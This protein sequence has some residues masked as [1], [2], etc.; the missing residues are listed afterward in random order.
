MNQRVGEETMTTVTYQS[1]SMEMTADTTDAEIRQFVEY[2]SQYEFDREDI[3]EEEVQATIDATV[4][5][6]IA[7][8]DQEFGQIFNIYRERIEFTDKDGNPSSGWR[9]G[10]DVVL[11]AEFMAEMY[12]ERKLEW[13]AVLACDLKAAREK[14]VAIW[15]P[16]R[17]E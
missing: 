13:I 5:G 2:S 8:R 10:S 14:A 7:A 9:I 4:D 15:F 17:H 3:S 12:P 16:H 11:S 1:F 6:L